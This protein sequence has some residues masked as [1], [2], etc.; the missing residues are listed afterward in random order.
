MSGPSEGFTELSA[1]H[2]PKASALGSISIQSNT[3]PFRVIDTESDTRIDALGGRSL[4]AEH[5]NKC[6]LLLLVICVVLASI[7]L[8]AVGYLSD[9]QRL[10][11]DDPP[12][13][14]LG[15]EQ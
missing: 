14:Q 8:G 6:M 7:V 11:G 13:T 3:L 2:E 4:S 15:I 1:I 12:R 9:E 5:I 10:S